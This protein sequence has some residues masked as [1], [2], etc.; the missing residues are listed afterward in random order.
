M[1]DSS[2]GGSLLVRRAKQK[3]LRFI[4]STPDFQEGGKLPTDEAML[5]RLDISSRIFKEAM[6]DLAVDGVIE[7]ARKKG[8][9]LVNLDAPTWNTWQVGLTIRPFGKHGLSSFESAL[10]QHILSGLASHGIMARTYLQQ[11]VPEADNQDPDEPGVNGERIRD[12]RGLRRDLD[13]GIIDAIITS[14]RLVASDVPVLTIPCHLQAVSGI[15]ISYARFVEQAVQ[16]LCDSSC[17]RL[18]MVMWDVAESK[19]T[20]I[21][22]KAFL[23]L[24]QSKARYSEPLIIKNDINEGTKKLV[25]SLAKLSPEERPDGLIITDD[26]IALALN[27]ALYRSDY[28]PKLA[29]LTNKQLN[30]SFS[31]DAEL[32][33]VDLAELTTQAMTLLKELLTN[34]K[35][36]DRIEIY[37]PKNSKDHSL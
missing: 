26:I 23:S 7:R 28:R 25:A 14:T 29:I 30:L 4:N 18:G 5:Q 36:I 13:A 19:Y 24:C 17:S 3:I 33:Y 10:N 31:D 21:G 37:N 1:N 20:D 12:F 8:N 9:I 27:N 16:V 22:W 32:F 6:Q 34:P 11:P 35:T 2:I 15:S